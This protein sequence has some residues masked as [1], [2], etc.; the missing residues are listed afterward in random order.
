MESQHTLR[1]RYNRFPYTLPLP[2]VELTNYIESHGFEVITVRDGKEHRCVIYHKEK[3][4]KVGEK[5]YRSDYEARCDASKQIYESIN[6][7]KK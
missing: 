6:K 5:R 4:L 7:K 1:E 3:V 2:L